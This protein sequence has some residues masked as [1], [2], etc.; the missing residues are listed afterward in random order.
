VSKLKKI[1]YA[2]DDPDIQEIGVL[3]METLGGFSVKTCDSGEEVAAAAVVFQPD[4]VVLDIMM[5]GM[6]GL[7]ALRALREIDAFKE[8]PVIFMTAKVMKDEQEQ[9]RQLGATDV[10]I[11]PFD[12]TTLCDR[13][14][15]I[16]AQCG[17]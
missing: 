5:P 3:A 7:E 13:I 11:K 1:L 14:L 15:E 12:P 17:E 8:T 10:I 9:Y 2:E 4:L 16:W 6:D